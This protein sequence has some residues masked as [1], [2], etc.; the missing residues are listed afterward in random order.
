MSFDGPTTVIA[1]TVFL[2]FLHVG[3][4]WGYHDGK[5]ASQVIVSPGTTVIPVVVHPVEEGTNP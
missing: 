5:K 4:L 2:L 1:L 3:Y